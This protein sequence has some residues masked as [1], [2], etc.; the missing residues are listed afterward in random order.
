M[1]PLEALRN[2]P[3]APFAIVSRDPQAPLTTQDAAALLDGLPEDI[4]LAVKF[5]VECD[6]FNGRCIDVDGGLSM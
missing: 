2:N 4:W 3:I 5:I 6:Y 1:D